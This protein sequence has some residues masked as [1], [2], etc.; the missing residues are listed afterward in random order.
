MCVDNSGAASVRVVFGVEDG[1]GGEGCFVGLVFVSSFVSSCGM[2]VF[3]RLRQ[4][5]VRKGKRL[6]FILN[7]CIPRLNRGH[8]TP[9]PTFSWNGD[10]KQC[11][12]NTRAAR[13]PSSSR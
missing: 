12:Q 3:L 13:A 11:T 6:V 9:F 10:K 8:H 5:N 1:G 4:R 2:F 7:F